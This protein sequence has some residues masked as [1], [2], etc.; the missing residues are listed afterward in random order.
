MRK[1]GTEAAWKTA[2]RRRILEAGFRLFAE[3]GIDAVT[4]PEVAEA[5]DVGRATRSSSSRSAWGTRFCSSHSSA[6][7]SRRDVASPSRA[8]P[9]GGRSSPRSTASRTSKSSPRGRAPISP[10][11]TAARLPTCSPPRGRWRPGPAAST[12]SSRAA[13]PARSSRSISPGR[14]QCGRSRATGAPTTAGSPRARRGSFRSTAASPAAR[15]RARSLRRASPTAAPTFR[16]C[17]PPPPPSPTRAASASFRSRHGRASA[18]RRSTGARSSPRFGTADSPPS[19]SAATGNAPKP[20]PRAGSA[21]RA[22]TPPRTPRTPRAKPSP[23]AGSPIRAPTP[24]RTP[25]TPRAKHMHP[26]CANLPPSPRGRRPLPR[27]AP[28]SA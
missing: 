3:K 18:G 25:R 6:R 21:I 11:S 2:K 5:C 14:A 9:L 23:R 28:S 27:A 10:A 16:I 1:E 15:S 8:G 22:P 4:M 24:P 7:C 19:F 13:I 17:S 26:P 12:A 20:S